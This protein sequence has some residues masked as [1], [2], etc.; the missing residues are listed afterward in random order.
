MTTVPAPLSGFRKLQV[1]MA[2]AGLL[3]PLNSSMIAVALPAIR[4]D[5]HVGVGA[6]T[7]LV[8]SY[9]IVV[10]VSQPVGGRL[11]DAVGHLRV[12]SAG[13]VALIIFSLAAA[14]SWNFASLVVFRSLQGIG[15]AFIMP[16]AVA[17]LRRLV[18]PARLGSVLGTN[19]AAISAGA[20]FGPVFG[21]IFVALGGWRWLFLANVPVSLVALW[22]VLRLQTDQGAGRKALRLDLV[23]LVALAG[24]FTGMTL[25]GSA[26]RLHSATII[27]LGVALMPV[28]MAAYGLRYR[29]KGRAIVDLRLFTRRNY[30]A[31]AA[32]T[33][34]SNLVMYSALIAMPIYLGDL[35][36]TSDAVIAA[37][38]FSMSIAM[39]TI[40]PFA[41]RASDRTGSRRPVVAGAVA[42]L[43]AAASLT[44]LVGGPPVAVLTLP[45]LLIGVSM[46]IAGAAQ[47]SAALQA[48]PTN[49]AG[50]AAGTY[51]MM[52]YVGSVT[53]TAIIAAVLGARPD[54]GAFRLLFAVMAVFAL[55]NIGAALSM[56][57]ARHPEA[58]PEPALE[59]AA[60]AGK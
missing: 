58:H 11:G 16:N 12:V 25:L 60:A 52:R 44:L 59:P 50:S 24:A 20:A 43:I 35:R 48:W 19:G 6:L 31:A 54:E 34:L 51:S 9:L 37:L 30:R 17:Y 49:M 36:H 28:S 45:L 5:F 29:Q 8:S 18:D 1:A 46:G 27:I 14:A 2:I 38:L 23:S 26:V 40:A 53:G 56:S 15:A 32:G 57:G 42:L 13:L 3:A 41:G 21:G 4:S 22:L 33:A 39:V 47:S 7:W 55:V 10:A